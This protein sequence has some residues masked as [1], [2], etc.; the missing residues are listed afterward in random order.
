MESKEAKHG[1]RFDYKSIISIGSNE[2]LI[3]IEV[4]IAHCVASNI[5]YVNLVSK[6]T[7][8]S[9]ETFAELESVATLVSDKLNGNSIALVI[10]AE[11]IGKLLASDYF[12][13]LSCF[14]IL[15]VLRVFLL[16]RV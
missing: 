16:N 9:T 10:E 1:N 12:Q 15:V 2:V 7:A 3:W 13:V 6:E 11:P 14:G 4:I 8:N 5:L